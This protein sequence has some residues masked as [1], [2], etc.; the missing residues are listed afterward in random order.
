MDVKREREKEGIGKKER[1]RAHWNS[2]VDFVPSGY[3][4]A[5]NEN[6]I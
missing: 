3:P 5:A 6:N 2:M 4:N 1:K